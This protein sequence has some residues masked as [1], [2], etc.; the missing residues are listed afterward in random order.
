M[1]ISFRLASTQGS[2]SMNSW[3]WSSS[4]RAHV[5]AGGCHLA[6]DAENRRDR[7]LPNGPGTGP[8]IAFLTLAAGESPGD[9]KP[10]SGWASVAWSSGLPSGEVLRTS[11]LVTVEP[12]PGTTPGRDFAQRQLPWR[13]QQSC[14]NGRS[15]RNAASLAGGAVRAPAP[16]VYTAA[17]REVRGRRPGYGTE[18]AQCD[19]AD[20][21]CVGA[22]GLQERSST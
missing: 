18:S 21:F 4:R 16:I 22:S 5:S 20:L 6:K 12:P 3:V 19:G 8:A 15:P 10:G 13:P 17:L 11:T 7:T 2:Q 1:A 14:G 9:T